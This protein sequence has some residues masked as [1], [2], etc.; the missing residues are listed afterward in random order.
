MAFSR[1]YSKFMQ[2]LNIFKIT[3]AIYT[4]RCYIQI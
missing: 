1:I 4:K 2:F 3:M